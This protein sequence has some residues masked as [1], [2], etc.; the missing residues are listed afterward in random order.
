MSIVA[1]HI[2]RLGID[3]DLKA[4]EPRLLILSPR[5]D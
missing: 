4:G 1:D 5:F 3:P 2:V